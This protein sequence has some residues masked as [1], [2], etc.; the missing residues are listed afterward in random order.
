[1]PQYLYNR[2]PMEPRRKQLRHAETSAE[3]MLWKRLR[4]RQ[5]DG[6]KW[7]RQYSVD[8]YVL[9]FYCP[10][11]RIAIE[12][13]GGQHA[14]TDV[15]AQDEERQRYLESHDIRVLRFWNREVI[16]NL[17]GVI[18]KISRAINM[19]LLTPPNR[20]RSSKASSPS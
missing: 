4:D 19:P 2:K 13:D 5:S 9:D 11:H 3:G 10:E 16:E 6:T 12:L 18:E 20:G 1:M 17:E 8:A 7:Y 15:K 14:Q